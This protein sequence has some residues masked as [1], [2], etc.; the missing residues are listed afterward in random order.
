M[1]WD[2]TYSVDGYWLLQ[3]VQCVAWITLVLEG[4]CLFLFFV[5]F[6]CARCCKHMKGGLKCCIKIQCNIFGM[7]RSLVLTHLGSRAFWSE[8]FGQIPILAHWYKR[9][10]QGLGIKDVK[11]YQLIKWWETMPI[12]PKYVSQNA[13]WPKCVETKWWNSLFCIYYID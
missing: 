13:L 2:Y 3:H 12:G 6:L 11:K 10:N 5:D 1:T 8:H 7:F 9:N 4:I